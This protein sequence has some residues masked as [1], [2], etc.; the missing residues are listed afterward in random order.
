MKKFPNSNI[1][2]YFTIVVD[3]GAAPEILNISV[4][5]QK[6]SKLTKVRNQELG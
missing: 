2:F 6:K 5:F 4:S 1:Y 3:I